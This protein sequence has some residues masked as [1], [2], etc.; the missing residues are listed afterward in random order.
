MEFASLASKKA[1]RKE[2][3]RDAARDAFRLFRAVGLPVVQ[4]EPRLPIALGHL[5]GIS[6]IPVGRGLR[7]G[8]G[9]ARLPGAHIG[10]A[11]FPLRGSATSVAPDWMRSPHPPQ[12]RYRL[13]YDVLGRGSVSRAHLPL[14]NRSITV[15]ALFGQSPHPP[16]H[17]RYRLLHDV[18]RGCCYRVVCS[19]DHDPAGGREAPRGH[20][21]S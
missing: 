21:S 11:A 2:L 8:R 17:R 20:V 13:V 18:V 9:R 1:R 14:D 6:P 4:T 7:G 12:H 16:Q 10:R 19:S 3:S 15:A 5:V